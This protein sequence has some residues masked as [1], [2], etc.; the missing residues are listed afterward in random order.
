M[1]G[2]FFMFISVRIRKAAF[3]LLLTGLVAAAVCAAAVSAAAEA[4]ARR[5]DAVPGVRLPVIMYHSI[6]KEKKR[7]GKYVVSPD[8]LENDLSYLQSKGYREI[9]VQDLLDYMDGKAELPEKPVMVTFDDGYYN[10]YVYA[11]PLA[12]KY[13]VKIVISPIGSYTDKFTSGDADHANYSYLT[14]NQI[15]EMMNSG[16]VEFQNH[17]YDLHTSRGRVGAQ[18]LWNES[19]EAYAAVLR[20]DLGRMQ[21]EMLLYT[22][23][24]PTAFIYPFGEVSKE[25]LPVLKE[26]GFRASM[27]CEEKWN[28]ITKD[29]GCLFGMGRFLR[30]EG[31]SSNA[32]FKKIGVT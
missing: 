23:Y 20:L 3:W 28:L 12:K 24:K 25:S 2:D 29:P 7:Q 16:L 19:A 30:P 10:N 26:I 13:G 4:A 21:R 22:G 27:T 5:A 15:G 9:V 31:L 32:Y 14:W 11:Y 17:T 1:R 8:T 6:L 18:K